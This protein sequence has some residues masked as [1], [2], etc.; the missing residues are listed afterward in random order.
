VRAV[1]GARVQAGAAAGA[2]ALMCVRYAHCAVR[3]RVCWVVLGVARASLWCRC[4]CWRALHCA[5]LHRKDDDWNPIH[6]ACNATLTRH[7][8]LRYSERPRAG[9]Q[10]DAHG[11]RRAQPEHSKRIV[12]TAPTH[13]TQLTGAGL[14]AAA[15]RASSVPRW[16]PRHRAVNTQHGEAAARAALSLLSCTGA[17]T[18]PSR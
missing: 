15:G 18:R 8:R 1:R 11:R 4:V 13:P 6:K 16:T 9:A 17:S 5:R 2:L 3:C 12:S 14:P 7:A 10:S